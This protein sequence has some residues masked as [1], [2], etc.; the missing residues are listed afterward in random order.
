MNS[1]KLLYEFK[2]LN[3]LLFSLNYFNDI[4]SCVPPLL[5]DRVAP[6]DAWL[7]VHLF[8]SHSGHSLDRPMACNVQRTLDLRGAS[9]MNKTIRK[10]PGY[11]TSRSMLNRFY[12]LIKPSLS[13]IELTCIIRDKSRPSF[14]IPS[15]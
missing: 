4:S 13:E 10:E 5:A 3:E 6:N 7:P 15:R 8:I 9:N 1:N 2:F 12:E 14:E 11:H